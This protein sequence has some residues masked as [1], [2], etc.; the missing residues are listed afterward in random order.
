MK[1]LVACVLLRA[2][3]RTSLER[4][5]LSEHYDPYHKHQPGNLK[6]NTLVGLGPINLA[7]PRILLEVHRIPV[8]HEQSFQGVVLGSARTQN[9][10]TVEAVVFL[11]MFWSVCFLQEWRGCFVLGPTS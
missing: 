3:P 11:G 10:K 6:R 7:Q 8:V 9:A 2:R 1:L 5:D 4:P